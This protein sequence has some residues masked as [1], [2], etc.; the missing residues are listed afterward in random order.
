MKEVCR[1]LGVTRDIATP[2]RP[3]CNYLVEKFNGTLMKMLNRL[4]NQKP[5][6]W[7]QYINPPL[8]PYRKVR[9]G[10][11]HFTPLELMYG[12]TVRGSIHNLRVLWT[13]DIDEQEVKS[14]YEY[15]LDMNHGERLKPSQGKA[16]IISSETEEILRLENK[17]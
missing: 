6:L 7:H 15:M 2:Y 5:K 3:M 12:R 9:Q 17:G 8:F 16:R 11:T 10:S 13:Q 14:S 1:L 4:C